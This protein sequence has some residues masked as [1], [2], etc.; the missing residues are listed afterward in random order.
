MKHRRASIEAWDC[1]EARAS[2]KRPGEAQYNPRL[3]FT[4]DQ[5][6]EIEIL[7]VEN[8]TLISDGDNLKT[9]YKKID[10]TVFAGACSGEFSFYVFAEWGISGCIHGR[11]ISEDA[12]VRKLRK[13]GL[14]LI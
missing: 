2:T 14:N 11:P 5:V 4:D 7:T 10:G 12:L 8:G 3:Y 6:R 9:Y 1:S 13:K